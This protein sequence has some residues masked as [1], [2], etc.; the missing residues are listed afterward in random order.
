MKYILYSPQKSKY[1]LFIAGR[2][3]VINLSGQLKISLDD[4]I[5]IITILN[6]R[7][8]RYIPQNVFITFIYLLEIF[9]FLTFTNL[10]PLITGYAM[11]LAKLIFSVCIHP[12]RNMTFPNCWNY[13]QRMFSEIK[14]S[15][16]SQVNTQRYHHTVSAHQRSTNWMTDRRG[17]TF[18]CFME[19]LLATLVSLDLCIVANRK[20]VST[21]KP[22]AYRS[23]HT[24]IEPPFL[25]KINYAITACMT[26]GFTSRK[27]WLK[28]KS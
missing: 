21:N 15:C 25:L 10:W 28:E 27:Y 12:W 18:R 4:F 24:G 3:H 26:L 19:V 17:R 6:T 1:P 22:V 11:V 16:R 7:L 2:R 20:L 23:V 13:A 8:V 5:F 9:F 14:Y